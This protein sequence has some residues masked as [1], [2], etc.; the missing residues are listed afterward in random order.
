MRARFPRAPGVLPQDPVTIREDL[1]LLIQRQP[2]TTSPRALSLAVNEP[3]QRTRQ[4][5]YD[6]K[7]TIGV[8]FHWEQTAG[9][10]PNNGRTPAK[11]ILDL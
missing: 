3:N 1:D 5:V 2:Y 4:S 10:L 8:P 6:A 11:C 9:L 7:A